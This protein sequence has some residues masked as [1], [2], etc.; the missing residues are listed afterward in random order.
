M[1]R[2]IKGGVIAWIA[3]G[4]ATAFI[5]ALFIFSTTNRPPS[6]HVA[7]GFWNEAMVR[8]DKN[9]P[10]KLIQYT[11]YFCSYCSELQESTAS[12][13]FD[14][15]YI[16]SNKLS[17]EVRIV[18]VLADISPNTEQG[19]ESAF[20]SA[21]QDK[22][23]EYSKHIVARIKQDYFD[24]GIGVKSFEGKMLTSPKPINKLPI[25][26]FS[27]SAKAVKMDVDKFTACMKDRIHQEEVA[28]NTKRAINLGIQGLPFIV[29]NDYTTSGF[30]GGYGGLELILKAGGVEK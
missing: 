16:K 18:A 8:G 28:E 17:Y 30:Q 24:R 20:C 13:Q 7:T 25:S 4:L 9:A 3:I 15:E 2:T 11:D 5:V 27:E 23:W 21:D 29:V 12:Q 1:K 6:P 10:N 19:A 22:F 14:E 26:Y